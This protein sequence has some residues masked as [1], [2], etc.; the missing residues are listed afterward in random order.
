M[1]KGRLRG[2]SLQAVTATRLTAGRGQVLRDD[3]G[4]GGVALP[5]RDRRAGRGGR[6]GVRE[7]LARA[8]LRGE[9]A[10]RVDGDQAYAGN[11]R[12]DGVG[13]T[14]V[15]AAGLRLVGRE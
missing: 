15:G 3:R 12:R 5:L 1:K 2:P 4:R 13:G 9:R 8:D 6:R 7:R 14:D 10:T 11:D